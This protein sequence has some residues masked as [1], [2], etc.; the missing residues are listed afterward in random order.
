MGVWQ[1]GAGYAGFLL[2]HDNQQAFRFGTPK[3]EIVLKRN[4]AVARWS[5]K[6][7]SEFV[8]QT[9]GSGR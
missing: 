7:R 5:R 1:V 6:A 2:V 8:V 9:M 3:S 4:S